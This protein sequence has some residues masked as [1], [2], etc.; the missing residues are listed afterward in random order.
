M[1]TSVA[2]KLPY[3]N[4]DITKEYYLSRLEFSLV[5][6]Y[7]DYMI[8]RKDAI[9]L[10]FFAFPALD[11]KKSDFMVYLRIDEGI[12]TFYQALQARGVEIHPNGRLEDKPW[13]MKEFALLDPNGTLLTFGQSC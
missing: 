8:M 10:H 5:S 2:P 7:P 4:A 9:E 1:I 12:T 6:Q 11:P 3:I 13:N